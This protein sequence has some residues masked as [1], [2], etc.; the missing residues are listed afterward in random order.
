MKK[1]ENMQRIW[2]ETILQTMTK[3]IKKSH[4]FVL[5]FMNINEKAIILWINIKKYTWKKEIL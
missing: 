2:K 4:I 3:Y 5:H 1:Y